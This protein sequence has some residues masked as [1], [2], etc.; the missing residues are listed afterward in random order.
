MS[1]ATLQSEFNTWTAPPYNLRMTRISGSEV[2]GQARYAAIFEKS[3]K[4]TGWVAYSAMIA[5]DF[6]GTN[7]I[8]QA[9]GFRLVWLDGFGVGTTAYYNG[10][11][12]QTFGAAQRVRT[13]E[14]LANHQSANAANEAD[15]YSL[16][17]VCSF[18]TDGTPLHAGVWQQGIVPNT[19]VRYS[20][21]SAQ[22]QTEFNSMSANG[23]YIYRVSGYESGTAERFTGVWRQS[24]LGEGWAYHGMR[25]TDFNAHNI[26]AQ[27]VGYRPVFVEAYNLGVDT[28][29][30]AVWIRNGGLSTSRLNTL[31]TAVQNYIS[32]RNIPGLSLA[33]AHEGHLVYARGFG[34]A[35]TSDGEVA[36]AQHRWRIASTSKTICAVSALRALEDSA[37]W[38]LD[39]KAFGSGA[40]FG[41][42]YGTLAYS[43][44][45][46][47]ITLRQLMNMTAGWNSQ[48]KLW[49]YDEPSYGTNHAAIIGY[50]L[51]SV[52][53]N[54]QPGTWDCY[55]NFNYQVAAR[56]PE[57]I[58]GQLFE[59]YTKTE[60]FDPCGITSMVLGERTAAERKFNEVAYYEGDQWG[61]PENIWPAR[62]DGSTGWITKPS[63]LLLLSRRIDGN[64]RHKDIIGSYALSQMQLGNGLQ[65]C[66]GGYSGYGLGWYPSTR[67]GKTWW[68]HNGAMAGTQAILVVSDDGSQAFAY[69]CNSVHSSD[70]PSGTFRNTILD[71]MDAIDD[72]NAWPNI[73]L[74]GKYNLDYDAWATTEF[75]TAVSRTGLI[76]FWAPDGD[77]DD[78]GRSNALEAFLGT[79][80]LA[81]NPP[82]WYSRIYL[83]DGDLILRW[84]KRIGYRGVDAVPESSNLVSPWAGSSATITN[85]TDLITPIGYTIQ[86]ARTPI[87]RG[88]NQR[89]LRVNISV[90]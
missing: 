83:D 31:A 33:I 36:H 11:W 32:A 19:Q 86:E 38:S 59:N 10:I 79:E 39:S 7:N 43:T 40:L 56:I 45:E 68:Q 49:Y 53:V 70:W 51:D 52:P 21:T 41:T 42:D 82:I 66:S 3:S 30:N 80:P 17:N 65:S 77:P 15:G 8:L 48:G 9:Q 50:Q 57:K 72:A 69:A 74:F 25:A 61:S 26:N 78:D 18:S 60:V 73:D 1:G 81:A 12:E 29:Y 6:T 27:M 16:V 47:E 5:S 62:M 24:S 85:R 22:Y 23:Y 87:P 20:L 13:G 67:N 14:S 35:D 46:K 28:F 44:W 2:S 75:G 54:W 76:D 37:A 64:P 88:A 89:F 34:Y 71:L 84:T 4:T 58:T 55:N 63:D 90:P